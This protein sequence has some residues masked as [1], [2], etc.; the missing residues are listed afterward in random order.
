VK[1]IFGFNL[2]LAIL[3]ISVVLAG[4]AS[5][6]T[7]A[8]TVPPTSTAKPVPPAG[9]G[10]QP[11]KTLEYTYDQLSSQ[12]QITQ[13]VGLIVSGSLI[14]TVFSN[15]TTGFSWA[16]AQISDTSII[17]QASRNYVEPNATA[18]PPVVGAGSK[19]VFVFDSLKEGPATIKISYSQ[20]W[21][22]GQKNVWTVTLNVV[23]AGK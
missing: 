9:G 17:K 14:V 8:P 15:R 16:D 23:A 11:A 4:C 7:P 10:G 13:D 18:T 12:K 22:G 5:Q 2:L 21:E 20:P 1:K 19:E 3:L 6:A